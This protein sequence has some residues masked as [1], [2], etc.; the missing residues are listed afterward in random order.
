MKSWSI[1]I[2]F[3]PAQTLFSAV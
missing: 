3:R 2:I 1:A